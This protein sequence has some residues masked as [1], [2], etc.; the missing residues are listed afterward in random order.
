[1]LYI[2]QRS[3]IIKSK[4]QTQPMLIQNASITAEIIKT[5]LKTTESNNKMNRLRL[6]SMLKLLIFLPGVI[7]FFFSFFKSFCQAFAI[8]FGCFFIVP[9]HCSYCFLIFIISKI[10]Q[11]HFCLALYFKFLIKFITQILL[12][13]IPFVF[14]L[15]YTF[16]FYLDLYL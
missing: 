10:C 5:Q 3:E 11:I 15:I 4:S 16:C 9:P 2:T 6:K 8:V 7:S 1:M 13:F 12:R 14:T